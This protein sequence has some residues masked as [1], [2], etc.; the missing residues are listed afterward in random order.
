MPGGERSPG[1]IAERAFDRGFKAAVAV[2]LGGIGLLYWTG[3][4]SLTSPFHAAVTLVLFPIYLLGVAVLL[5]AWLGFGT[6]ET[7]LERVIVE[8]DSEDPLSDP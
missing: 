1:P 4:L 7:D 8:A 3:V 5:A 6:D 2:G